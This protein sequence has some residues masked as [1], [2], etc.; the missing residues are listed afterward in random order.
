MSAYNN[1]VFINASDKL[2]NDSYRYVRM[3]GSLYV[4]QN[5]YTKD[6]IKLSYKLSKH[7]D[8]NTYAVYY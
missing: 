2:V 4:Y 1:I 5:V 3:D 8:T 6:E 7:N